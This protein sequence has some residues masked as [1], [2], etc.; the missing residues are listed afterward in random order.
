MVK[1]I[2]LTTI[3]DKLQ[4]IYNSDKTAAEYTI[5]MSSVELAI[6]ILLLGELEIFIAREQ[7]E[8]EEGDDT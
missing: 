1:P 4:E 3:K 7:E 6:I 5:N 8:L 2:D